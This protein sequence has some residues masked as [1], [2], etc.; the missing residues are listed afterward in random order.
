LISV[1]IAVEAMEAKSMAAISNA[2]KLAWQTAAEEALQSQHQFIET[3]HLYIG[4]CGLEKFSGR[5]AEPLD[6]DVAAEAAAVASALG[7]LRLSPHLFRRE[8]RRR[9][10]KGG[11]ARPEGQRVSRSLA[12]KAAFVRANNLLP[13][14]PPVITS[15]HLLAALFHDERGIVA[16]L[17]GE[18]GVN[19]R[20]AE[21]KVLSAAAQIK[22]RPGASGPGSTLVE[23]P[24]ATLEKFGKDLTALALDGKIGECIGRDEE[25]LRIVQ[26]LSRET[27]NNPLLIGDPGIGKTAI[28]EG[29]AW[30]LAHNKDPALDGRRLI[31]INLAGLIAGTKYR[32][33]LE[34]RI[35]RILNESA[36][37]PNVILFIDEIDAIA[38]GQGTFAIAHLLKP[39]L[40]RG[41]LRCIGAT[42]WEG[43][44][45]SIEKDPALERRFQPIYIEEPSPDKALQ[46]LEVGY[47]KRLSTKH[48]VTI[49]SAALLAAVTLSM[50]Y[51]PDRRLPDKAIDLLDEACSRVSVPKLGRDPAHLRDELVSAEIVAK[52]VAD[53]TKLPIATLSG[54]D[55]ERLLGMAGALR[56]RVIGQDAA[57]EKVAQMVQRAYT[58]LKHPERPVAV[59]LLV[60]P[61]GVGKTELAKATTEFLFGDPAALIR[62]DM[63]EYMEK[64]SISRLIGT[65]PGFIG[66]DEEPQLTGALRRRPYSIVLIDEVEKAHPEVLN[67]FLQLFDEGRLTDSRGR[68]ASGTDAI[69]FLTSNIASS[70]GPAGFQNEEKIDQDLLGSIR[71]AFRPE[72]WNRFDAVIPFHSLK[73]EDLKKIALLLLDS[74]TKQLKSKGII[75]RVRDEA[76]SLLAAA[77]D[78]RVSGARGLRRAIEQQME[79]GISKLLLGERVVSGDGLIVGVHNGKLTFKT[80]SG[81]TAD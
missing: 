77:G 27:K 63:S 59:L 56:R 8:I 30:R 18:Q 64:H 48:H 29:L 69:F 67:L 39:A 70:H 52:V 41:E 62:I 14:S 57:C 22:P 35:D 44:S 60:G 49:E 28:V 45:Q 68:M 1:A 16:T 17:L 61:T 42:T 21:Q 50:R 79:S 66:H 53:W 37:S 72:L 5:L 65:P 73:R 32:G 81:A 46:I 80:D 9:V 43:Y 40:A 38:N 12:V 15:L 7:E 31:Q 2:F 58:G 26:A 76:I 25:I 36:R 47:R 3:G 78:D 4:I 74:L 10:G 51:L 20:E 19:L 34:E 71:A 13:I 11:Y 75:L 55:R 33:E 23:R 6:E 24:H 54:G